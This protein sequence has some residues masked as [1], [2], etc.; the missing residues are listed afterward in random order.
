MYK[1]VVSGPESTGKTELA[2]FLAK[3]FSCPVIPEYAREYIEKLGRPYRFEDVEHIA[4]V[5]WDQYREYAKKDHPFLIM[6]TFLFITKIWFSEVFGTV[7]GWIDVS[8]EEAEIDLCLLCYPDLEWIED[9]VR[10]NPGKRRR[11][12]F[13]L[14]HQAIIR[15]GV[16]CEV[17]RGRGDDRFTNALSAIHKQLPGLK[18]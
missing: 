8:L 3:R 13:D 14:Y 11:E 6:D 9:T 5:Q 18:N 10:E 16:A 2:C 15:L 4:R 17:I 7:P 1:L 12:L